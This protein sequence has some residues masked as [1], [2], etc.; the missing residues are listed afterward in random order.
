[1]SDIKLNLAHKKHHKLLFYAN[2]FP[3]VFTVAQPTD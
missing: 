3:Y 2:S 1:M